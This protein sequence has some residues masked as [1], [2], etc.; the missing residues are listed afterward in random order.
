MVGPGSVDPDP[1]EAVL[2]IAGARLPASLVIPDRAT[3]VVIF[4]HGSGS[5]RH[6]PRN[7]FVAD[8]LNRAG[9]GTLLVDLLT[10]EEDSA[11]RTCSTFPAR[12]PAGRDHRLAALPA[13]SRDDS[14]RLLRRE[15]RRRRRVVGRRGHPP[16]AGHGDRFPRRPPGPGRWTAGRVQAP[17]LLIV[18]GEDDWSSASTGRHRQSSR[19]KTASRSSRA[20]PTCSRSRG[21]RAG[22]RTER[23]T[24]SSGISH[25]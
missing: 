12:G 5:S 13:G 3:G 23:G 7:R 1:A 4:A 8:A 11:A 16:A 10:G 6:S 2:N 20:R 19:A 17:T 14:A 18:G 21:A 9:L 22:G 25:R 15:H 24:G